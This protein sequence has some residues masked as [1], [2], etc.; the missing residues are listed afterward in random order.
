[1]NP[2]AKKSADAD[3]GPGISRE[4]W[5]QIS[6]LVLDNTRRREVAEATGISFG[7][8]RALRRLSKKPMSMGE[9]AEAM[10]IDPPNAT[11]VVDDLEKLKLV[12]RKPHPTDRRAKLV[13]PT[14]KGRKIAEQADAILG[15]PPPELTS[16]DSR[17]LKELRRILGSLSTGPG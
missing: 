15:T 13:E 4:V 9:F 8:T 3:Q 16:L 2:P 11:V 1:M 7:R 17:D 14:A 5:S 10:Q 6:S 12:R